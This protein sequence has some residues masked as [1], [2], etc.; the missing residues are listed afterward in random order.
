MMKALT[1]LFSCVNFF[2][3]QYI[4]ILGLLLISRQNLNYDECGESL[5]ALVVI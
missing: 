1:F 5:S 2:S 4:M 3:H